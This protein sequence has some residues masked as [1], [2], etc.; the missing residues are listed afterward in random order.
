MRLIEDVEDIKE[1][2]KKTKTEGEDGWDICL[3]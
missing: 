1:L 2:E 3:E